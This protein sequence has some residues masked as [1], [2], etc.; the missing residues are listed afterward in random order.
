[1]HLSKGL[2]LSSRSIVLVSAEKPP[3]HSGTINFLIIEVP[4][5]RSDG[6]RDIKLSARDNVLFCI[7]RDYSCR[8]IL[9]LDFAPTSYLHILNSR[10]ILILREMMQAEAAFPAAYFFINSRSWLL[11][12]KILLLENKQWTSLFLF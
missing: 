7:L 8:A 2:H 9:L 12:S 6:P 4:R 3:D 5:L 10:T 1:M 11:I